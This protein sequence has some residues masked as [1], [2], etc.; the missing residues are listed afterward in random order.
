MAQKWPKSKLK[1]PEWMFTSSDDA[2]LGFG[3]FLAKGVAFSHDE[4]KNSFSTTHA[5]ICVSVAAAALL[6]ICC[7]VFFCRRGVCVEKATNG[8]SDS[9][10]D[11]AEPFWSSCVPEEATSDAEFSES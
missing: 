10:N 5:I 11:A 6:A 3:D 8:H 2:A 9:E 1:V 7:L 4:Q